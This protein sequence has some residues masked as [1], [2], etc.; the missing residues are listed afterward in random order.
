MAK[1][2]LFELGE[3][4]TPFFKE[5]HKCLFRFLRDK[6]LTEMLIFFH[7]PRIDGF[8]LRS[9]HQALGYT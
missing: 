9:S 4:G 5:S 2:L 3:I 6:H 7:H 8:S 1:Y